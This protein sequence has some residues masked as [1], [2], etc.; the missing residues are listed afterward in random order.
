MLVFLLPNASPE[1]IF[2]LIPSFQSL[3]ALALRCHPPDTIS[4]RQREEN[5]ESLVRR[6]HLIH[7]SHD[8]QQIGIYH[9]ISQVFLSLCANTANGSKL[10]CGVVSST[11]G[12]KNHLG[13]TTLLA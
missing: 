13:V 2:M 8:I 1:P 6:F 12:I 10:F 11:T 3:L 4:H 5:P 7:A 9:Q